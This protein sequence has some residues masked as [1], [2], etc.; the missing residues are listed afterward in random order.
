MKYEVLVELRAA[1]DIERVYLLLASEAPRAAI[2]WFNGIYEAIERLDA[3]P[4]RCPY[5]P[6]NE[7][8]VEEIRQLLYGKRSNRYR[9]LFTIKGQRIHVLH[10]RHG[11]RQWWQRPRAE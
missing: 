7:Y 1:A 10:V 5:A 3:F 6:E 8:F 9:I 4:T 11:R 2:K